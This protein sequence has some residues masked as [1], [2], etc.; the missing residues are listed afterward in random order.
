MKEGVMYGRR[1]VVVIPA[2]TLLC[3]VLVTLTYGRASSQVLT[4][5]SLSLQHSDPDAVIDGGKDGPSIGDLTFIKSL[6]VDDDGSQV[7]AIIAQASRF[8]TAGSESLFGGTITLKERGTLILSGKLNLSGR[9][10]HQGTV[11]VVGGTGDF[12]G[13]Q[14]VASSTLDLDSGGVHIQIM[15]I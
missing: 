4:T 5:L 2:A 14:G 10:E 8:S 13:A 12:E 15:L 11:A 6:L 9:T 1:M 7:G 3:L